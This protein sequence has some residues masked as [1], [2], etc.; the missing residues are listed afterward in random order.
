MRESKLDQIRALG[1]CEMA[2]RY[3]APTPR[4]PVPAIPCVKRGLSTP[5][6]TKPVDTGA[7]D[8]LDRKAY[9]R[10][11]VRK[12]RAAKRNRLQAKCLG[13]RPRLLGEPPG[14]LWAKAGSLLGTFQGH[15]LL[16]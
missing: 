3:G 2:R 9:Q 14:W 12:Q 7:V 4:K 6:D 15:G 5:V 1:S 10:E 13:T 11:W 8:T 16:V